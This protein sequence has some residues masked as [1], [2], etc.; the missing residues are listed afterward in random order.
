MVVNMSIIDGQQEKLSK[1]EKL[2]SG[3]K[4]VVVNEIPAGAKNVCCG[5]CTECG[6]YNMGLC[7]KK[8]PKR[9]NVIYVAY[10]N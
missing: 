3:N 6:G 4:F 8:L 9:N 1:F 2:Y 10:H 7:M 5:N